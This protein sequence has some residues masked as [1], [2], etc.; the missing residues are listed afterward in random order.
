MPEEFEVAVRIAF[1]VILFEIKKVLAKIKAIERIERELS[2]FFF[3][4]Y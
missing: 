3:L 1:P 2:K 4:T